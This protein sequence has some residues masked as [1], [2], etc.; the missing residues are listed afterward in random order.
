MYVKNCISEK[1]DSVLVV[2]IYFKD[3]VGGGVC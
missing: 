3:I 2:K 1:F